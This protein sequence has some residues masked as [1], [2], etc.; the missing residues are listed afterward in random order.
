ML[1]AVDW[2][3][4]GFVWAATLLAVVVLFAGPA[5]IGADKE[6]PAASGSAPPAA[7]SP[8]ATVFSSAGCGSCHTLAAAQSSGAVGPNL[9]ETSLDAAGVAA[10]VRDG[11]GA[12]PSFADRLSDAEIDAVA[13]F[14]VEGP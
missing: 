8:G 13:R 10:V 5:L 1:R 2:F 7:E 12:M 6:E 3:L 11:R 4:T 14:V 9:D